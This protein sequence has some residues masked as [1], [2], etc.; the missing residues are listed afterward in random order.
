MAITAKVDTKYWERCYDFL[1][2]QLL[3]NVIENYLPVETY[4]AHKQLIQWTETYT[5]DVARM[6]VKVGGKLLG[7]DVVEVHST[8]VRH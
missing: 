7:I 4:G 1:H 8:V 3:V 6:L 2:D 5:L